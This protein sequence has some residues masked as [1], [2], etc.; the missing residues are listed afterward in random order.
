VHQLRVSQVVP[1][2]VD[3]AWEFFSDPRNLAVITPPDMGFVIHSDVPAR[4]Y[5]G[6]M[7]EY[8]V[9]PV[10]GIP[11]RWVTEITHVRER[12]Y[13]VDEQRAGPYRLWH[14][15]HHFREVPGGVEVSDIV[16]YALPFGPPGA[17]VNRLVVSKR[18][19]QIFDY[20]RA[21]LE[22]RF[23]AAKALHG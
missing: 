2:T 12:E 1:L 21:V 5:P 9:R 10:L 11:V 13:F 20:R 8:T 16:S 22:D 14:H 17:L 3:Q 23:G 15:E 18:L 19:A 4:M 6:L 7:I